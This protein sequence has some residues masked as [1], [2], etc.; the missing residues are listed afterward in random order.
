MNSIRITARASGIRR[1]LSGHPWLFRDDLLSSPSDRAGQILP[2][3]DGAG[4]FFGQ[5]FYNPV[6]RIAFRL[7]TR[8]DRAV[9][10]AFWSEK[11]EEA[12]KFR[13]SLGIDS[14]A[15][16]LV[17]S[18]TDGFPGLVVDDY[19]GYLAVQILTLGRENRKGDLLQILDEQLRPRA[20][21]LRNDAPVR[22]LEGLEQE[23]YVIAGKLPS[24]VEVRE[25][26]LHFE[27]DLLEGQKTGAYLDQR[28]NRLYLKSF[29]AG[30]RVL[31][32]FSYDGWFAIHLAAQ[33]ASSVLALD[34]SK[35][36]LDRLAR[37]ASRNG[38]QNIETRKANCFDALKNLAESEERFDLIVLDPPPFARRKVD[39]PGALKAY[40]EI[41]RRALKC[42]NP[43]GLL[44]TCCCSPG[45][46]QDRF[47]GTV[48]TAAGKAR[49][50]LL[51][52]AQRIQAPDHPVLFNEPE[53]LY[54]KALLL[55]VL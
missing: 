5:G 45:I 36:A 6:S 55:K 37:N 30:R 8:D 17:F 16:R 26:E 10:R 18:E 46:S 52:L 44:F 27:V 20:M 19:G 48:A 14:T 1:I 3:F 13:E 34:S 53:S 4:R 42:L 49:R 39:I 54:L 40:K 11:L 31:D 24:A 9:D 12:I 41:H 33:G 25:G 22:K 47:A 38:V 50:R 43:G 51:L 21:V 35:A 23:R 32:A 28:E 7:I 29:G 2:L 15:R